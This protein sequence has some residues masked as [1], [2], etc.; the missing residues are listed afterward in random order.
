MHLIHRVL[1]EPPVDMSLYKD[2]SCLLCIFTL[3]SHIIDSL[4]HYSHEHAS[5]PDP[6][7]ER[8]SILPLFSKSKAHHLSV[9]MQ[10]ILTLF[11]SY[12][13]HSSRYFWLWMWNSFTLRW[14]TRLNLQSYNLHISDTEHS[15]C[16]WYYY[17]HTYGAQ[18]KWLGMVDVQVALTRTIISPLKEG[19]TPLRSRK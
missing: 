6:H 12:L 14:L 10:E 18:L 11:Y 5:L 15:T 19:D 16:K 13:Y 9:C 8:A 7:M 17:E 4:T 1:L 2:M 3:H